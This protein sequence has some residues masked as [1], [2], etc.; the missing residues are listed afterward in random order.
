MIIAN[1]LLDNAS[2]EHARLRAWYSRQLASE[3]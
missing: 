3:G 2:T 1:L